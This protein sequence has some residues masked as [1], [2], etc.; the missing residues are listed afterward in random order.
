MKQVPHSIHDGRQIREHNTQRHN[1]R[2]RAY[3]TNKKNIHK[4]HEQATQDTPQTFYVKQTS[5][6]K[7]Y[8]TP[9]VEIKGQ[10]PNRAG[11]WQVTTGGKTK[12]MQKEQVRNKQPKV[13]T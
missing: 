1:I 4:K 8:S 7:G 11:N 13:R 10:C 5:T 9:K 6:K 3:N 12:S 2:Q